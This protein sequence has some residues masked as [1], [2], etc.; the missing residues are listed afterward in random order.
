MTDPELISVTELV[1]I[2]YNTAS[3]DFISSPK[4][5]AD[6]KVYIFSGSEDTIVHQGVSKKLNEYYGHF[7]NKEN[8]VTEFSVPAQHS[9]VT[10][11][12]GN[13]CD[14]KG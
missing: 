6:S 12:Y 14:Y 4:H 13:S 5:L 10:D 1:T 2:T 7:V 9:W 3:M 8:I 11:S